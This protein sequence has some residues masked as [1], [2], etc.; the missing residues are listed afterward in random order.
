MLANWLTEASPGRGRFRHRAL[1]QK[2]KV[3]VVADEPVIAAVYLGHLLVSRRDQQRGRGR[4]VREEAVQQ[5]RS[6]AFAARVG[7]VTR[8]SPCGTSR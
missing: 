3:R 7:I 2:R 8:G 6:V 1:Q 4:N 5:S